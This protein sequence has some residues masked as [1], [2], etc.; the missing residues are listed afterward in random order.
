[1][2]KYSISISTYLTIFMITVFTQ[3]LFAQS[4]KVLK[5][6]KTE[7]FTLTGKG[8]AE[9]W[10]TAEWVDLPQR[11]KVTGYTGLKTRIKVL[12]SN[13]G[14][15]FL[16]ECEDQVL[17]ATMNADFMKLWKEDVVEVF[18]WPD[19]NFP[20][21]FEYELSPLNYELPILISNEQGDLVRWR[22]YMYESDRQTRHQ[23]AVEGGEKKSGAS[24]TK[25]W[26]EFFIP[27]KLLRPLNNIPPT[28]GTSWKANFYRVDYDKEIV[29]YTWQP[30]NKTFH[31]YKKFGALLFD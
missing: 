27:F 14:I 21:Y 26:A 11:N 15:Y 20:V 4:D 18:L 23:T 5:V 16:F 28:S 9:N 17:N 29:R 2:I 19:I 24:V 30:I 6:K 1:M 12:Y 7:D 3:A 8:T 10:S 31:E 22:P 25:W 13:T